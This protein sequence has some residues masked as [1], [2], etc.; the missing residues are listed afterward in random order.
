MKNTL[1]EQA[2]RSTSFNGYFGIIINENNPKDLTRYTMTNHE[3]LKAIE[4]AEKILKG[5]R[6]SYPD[7]EKLPE[8]TNLQKHFLFL[9][10]IQASRAKMAYLETETENTEKP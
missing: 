9:L 8:Y 2:D 3:L 1:S 10:E 6:D 5:L 7:Y 4:C